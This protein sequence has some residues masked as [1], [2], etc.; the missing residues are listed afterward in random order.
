G[1]PGVV[2]G[3]GGP[4]RRIPNTLLHPEAGPHVAADRDA[5]GLRTA[6]ADGRGWLPGW[7]WLGWTIAEHLEY[8]RD[9]RQLPSPPPAPQRLLIL[10]RRAPKP[11]SPHAPP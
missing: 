9:V 1:K 7:S 10:P 4:G 3:S 11:T 6:N 5:C 2:E 8:Q